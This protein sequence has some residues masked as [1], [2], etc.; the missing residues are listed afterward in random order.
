MSTNLAK[1]RKMN[2]LRHFLAVF[3]LVACTQV[4]AMK[5][6]KTQPATIEADEVEMDFRT[7]ERTYQ[8]NVSVQQGTMRITADKLIATYK[9][10]KLAKATAFGNPAVFRQR[11]EGKDQD[12]VG[13]AKRLELDQI[14]DLVTLNENASLTQDADTIEGKTIV[15]NLDTEKMLVQ[16][17]TTQTTAE[18]AITTQVEA[19]PQPEEA[20]VESKAE[21]TPTEQTRPRITIQPKTTTT[22]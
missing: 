2:A 21:E 8:G 10:N 4:M 1:P 5:S 19:E 11:P 20:E 14:Q 22:E 7:G 12:V 13:K 16:G 6:D 17:G 18:P 3:A 15:Y 9:D